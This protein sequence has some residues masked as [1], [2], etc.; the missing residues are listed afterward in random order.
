LKPPPG[1]CRRLH[2]WWHRSSTMVLSAYPAVM[3]P[4]SPG[5]DDP[6]TVP[7]FRDCGWIRRA[8]NSKLVFATLRWRLPFHA[9]VL[10]CFLGGGGRI[11]P[12]VRQDLTVVMVI[13][14]TC[15]RWC[16]GDRNRSLWKANGCGEH[17]IRGVPSPWDSTTAFATVA[18]SLPYSLLARCALTFLL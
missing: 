8:M 9:V 13:D 11:F 3:L 2:R 18:L 15:S 17:Y 12:L 5:G 7:P 6:P 16:I 10:A 4:P 14:E 1:S